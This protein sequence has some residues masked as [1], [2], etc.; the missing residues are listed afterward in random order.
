MLLASGQSMVGILL[1][2]SQYAGWLPIV[3][4]DLAP[5]VRFTEVEK[6]CSRCGI[7]PIQAHRDHGICLPPPQPSDLFLTT[8]IYVLFSQNCFL[9]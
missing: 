2:I 1:N 7:Q 8:R 4:N 3:D 6:S 9:L 5:N